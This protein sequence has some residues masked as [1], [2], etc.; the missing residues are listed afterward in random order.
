MS[1]DN[2]FCFQCEQVAGGEA[3]TRMG[4][5][6]KDPDVAGLQ[7][8]VIHQMMGIGVLG[9]RALDRGMEIPEDISAFVEE[10]TFETLTNVDFDPDRFHRPLEQ[11]DE[12]KERM[13]EMVGDEPGDPEPVTYRLPERD[14]RLADALRVGIM[15]DPDLNEDVRSPRET[16]IYGM[17]GMAAYAY[18]ARLLGEV[19]PAVDAF[20]YRGFDASVTEEDPDEL[21]SMLLKLGETNLRCMEILDKA[22]TG[23]YGHPEPTSV[24]VTVKEGPFIVVSGHDLKD[25]KELLEQTE[26]MGINVYTHGEMLPALAYPELKK[27]PHLVGNYGGAWQEQ[28]KE[29][30]GIPGT[31]L[32]TTNCIQKP[33]NS[34]M[35]RIFT[36]GPAGWPGVAHIPEG[37][38]RKDLSPVIDK[39]LE[40]GGWPEDEE[41]KR[42]T[43]GFD[44]NA[45]MN[46]AGDVIEA[47]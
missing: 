36:T 6:G 35:D 15:S 11:G 25:L 28:Q 12:A 47:V 24:P 19:D 4:V 22:N 13:R 41:E 7:D 21:L 33:R 23:A 31:I 29:F 18:H 2:M 17:K 34:Y 20:F 38:G 26:G 46:V 40:L 37:D 42:I 9:S 43:V 27:Y 8:L 30:D 3:C 10:A 32:M 44:R 5:C 1:L 45:V 39:A 14:E 16:L